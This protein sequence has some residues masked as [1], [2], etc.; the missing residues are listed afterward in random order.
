MRPH[1]RHNQGLR[2]AQ[3][4]VRV[5]DSIRAPMCSKDTRMHYS[6]ESEIYVREHTDGDDPSP[7]TLGTEGVS[8]PVC[9]LS[10]ST[11]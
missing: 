7:T 4:E 1:Q 2:Y 9:L 10:T 5:S 11:C 3:M 6:G 8:P